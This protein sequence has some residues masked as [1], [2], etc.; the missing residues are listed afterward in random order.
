[1]IPAVAVTDTIK[2][3]EGQWWCRRPIE[4]QLVAAQTPQGFDAGL[5]RRAYDSEYD[6]TD[7]A[8]LASLAGAA[9]AVVEGETTNIKITDPI[10][11]ETRR[12]L[13][14]RADDADACPTRGMVTSRRSVSARASTSIASATIRRDGWCSVD[15]SSPVSRGS[16]G[17]ATPMWSPTPSPTRLLGAA[18]LGDIGQHYP[19]TD[20]Q[21]QGA[22]SMRILADVVAM[23]A[24][25]GWSVGNVDCS[26]VCELP[27]L[28]PQREEMQ[29]NG[30]PASLA[31]RSA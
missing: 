1:M 31:P 16:S 5:L 30:W 21:W 4:P 8:A 6:A 25:D 11:L 12:G 18:G 28:A 13:A 26:V 14:A 27:K 10:D 2:E 22:D 23:V 3:V 24:A 19:D 17:T 9:V 15:A 29:E 20:P 7:D